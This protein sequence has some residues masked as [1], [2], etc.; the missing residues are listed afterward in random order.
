MIDKG[1][2]NG[3]INSNEIKQIIA[4]LFWGVVTTIVGFGVYYLLVNIIKTNYLLA[5]VISWIIAVLTAFVSNKVFVFG[6]RDCSAFI[7]LKELL[8][9]VGSRVSTGL[10]DTLLL[11]ILVTLLGVNKIVSKVFSSVIV[12]I[13][14]YVFSKKYVF[15]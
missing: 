5:N 12:I 11:F 10:L 9:F 6:K 4:Y 7:L 3:K 1:W 13:L 15:K 8:S 14:N 2:K